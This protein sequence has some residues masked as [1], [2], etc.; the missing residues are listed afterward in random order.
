[1]EAAAI[2]YG[3]LHWFGNMPVSD[4]LMI[5]EFR[6]FDR[7]AYQN[8]RLKL[9]VFPPSCHPV[10]NLSYLRFRCFFNEVVCLLSFDI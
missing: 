7:F 4:H 2:F 6:P 9:G 8:L 3:E 10:S 1:M 5:C